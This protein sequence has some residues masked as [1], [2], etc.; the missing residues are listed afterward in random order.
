MS[1]K[2]LVIE[3]EKDMQE[4]ICDNLQFENY[5]VATANDGEEGLHKILH[6]N[7]DLIIL[8]IMLPKKNGIEICKEIRNQ[9]ITTPILF[10]TA[11]A[12]EIDRV[13]GLEIGGDDYLCKPF[14][15]RELL[16]RVKVLL[17]RTQKSSPSKTLHIGKSVV[18]LQRFTVCN[19]GQQHEM[20]HYEVDI[21]Q[22]LF[23][24][25]GQVVDRNTILD[26]IWGVDAYPSNRTVDNYI[27]KIR[28]K[29]EP[30]PNKPKYFI[31]VHG[32]G[33]KLTEDTN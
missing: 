1:A 24:H 19:N 33:Y 16:A 30:N 6:T 8:D 25:R 11:R 28:K 29:I 32:V 13:L 15:M 22:L 9:S 27:V 23:A 7:P 18:D 17:R 20:S 2:I 31:T 3:D 26:K 21:I 4:V 10:L 14:F 5:T 12:S